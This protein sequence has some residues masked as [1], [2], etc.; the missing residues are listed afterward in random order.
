MII[1]LQAGVHIQWSLLEKLLKLLQD[2]YDVTEQLSHASACISEV[3]PVVY[4]LTESLDSVTSDDQGVKTFK[5]KPLS[6][7]KKRMSKY[8]TMEQY[9]VATL[10]DQRYIRICH[11]MCSNYMVFLDTRPTSSKTPPI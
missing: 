11:Y 6:S 1:F 8:E 5:A 4:M 10:L 7:V 3:I 2:F 9:S